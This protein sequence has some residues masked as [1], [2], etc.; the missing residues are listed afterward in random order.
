ML[1]LLVS[2]VVNRAGDGLIAIMT[3]FGQGGRP[4]QPSIMRV[5]GTKMFRVSRHDA[6]LGDK[7]RGIKN[8]RKNIHK[9][10]QHH[11]FMLTFC[12]P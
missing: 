10:R 1:K 5:L 6:M 8:L 11:V 4:H 9:D 3:T 12:K 7:I 2:G